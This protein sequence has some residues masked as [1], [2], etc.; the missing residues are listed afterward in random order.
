MTGV[1]DTEGGLDL[2]DVESW[3]AAEQAAF[4]A[5]YGRTK[6]GMLPGHDFWMRHRP[7][8]LKRYRVFAIQMNIEERKLRLPKIGILCWLHFYVHSGFEDG[9]RYQI[10]HAQKRASTT[11]AAIMDTLAVAFLH[12]GPRGMGHVAL[13]SG[14]YLD[15]YEEPAE[16]SGWPEG[17]EHDP[18]AFHTGLDYSSPELLDGEL[19][20]IRE[21][22]LRVCGE[23]PAYVDFLGSHR[24]EVLKAYRHRYEYAIRDELPKQ[25]MPLLQL[26]WDV[27][28]CATSGIRDDLLLARG[29]MVE[30]G[31]VLDAISRGLLYSSPAGVAAVQQAAGDILA[32]W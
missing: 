26:Q 7:D 9:I 30:K 31:Y 3:T 11:R 8:V 29:L 5:Y 18:A 12:S 24:P 23:V 19:D 4:E 22:Y 32:D 21:W 6:D 1:V 16:P 20:R 2:S 27:I 25:M 13:S 15:T 10:V 17:W 14:D 28:R